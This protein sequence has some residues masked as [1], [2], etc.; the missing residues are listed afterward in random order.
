MFRSKNFDEVNGAVEKLIAVEH[1]QKEACKNKSGKTEEIYLKSLEGFSEGFCEAASFNWNR[2]TK[3]PGTEPI[4]LNNCEIRA[5]Q[6]RRNEFEE[7]IKRKW[8][9]EHPVADVNFVFF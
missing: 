8:E 1:A 4:I 9:M 2:E 3:N 7:E 5:I 6:E